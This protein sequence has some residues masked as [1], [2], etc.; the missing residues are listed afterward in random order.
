MT[1][2]PAGPAPHTEKGVDKEHLAKALQEGL[3]GR[4]ALLRTYERVAEEV[5]D[6]DIQAKCREFAEDEKKE[7]E[8]AVEITRRYGGDPGAIQGVKEEVAGFLGKQVI[9]GGSEPYH[10]A[11]DLAT[12]HGL[13]AAG[14]AGASFMKKVADRAGDSQWSDAVNQSIH[15]AERHMEYLGEKVGEL[16]NQA[17][18]TR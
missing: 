12:L 10:C 14:Y 2:E 4:K 5:Q 8:E 18:E 13:E 3:I 15:T 16:G 11:K 9:S 1:P 6:A 7:Y 17:F